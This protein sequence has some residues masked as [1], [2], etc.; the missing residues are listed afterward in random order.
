[1]KV[2]VKKHTDLEE[3]RACLESTMGSDFSSAATLK[4][5]YGWEH[6]IT[7]SQ[8]FS[9][10]LINIPTFVSVHMVRHNI[11]IVHYVKSKRIDRDGDGTEDRYTP[12][13]HRLLCNAEALLNMARKRL[14]FQASKETREVM[15]MIKEAIKE[16]DPDLATY[17]Q[18]NCVY[19]GGICSEPKP[20]GNYAIKRYDPEFREYSMKFFVG[21]SVE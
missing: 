2:I 21:D 11:G 7:R 18:P 9:V 4:Q 12:V 5:I 15:L 16:V 1:M 6:S 10:Q 19:R 3:A 17:M 13:N 8:F 20:C 14:C